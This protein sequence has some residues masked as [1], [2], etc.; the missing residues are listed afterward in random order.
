MV[1]RYIPDR[2]D[3]V[4]IKF[5]PQT[6]HEQAG[7]RPALVISP[8]CIGNISVVAFYIFSSY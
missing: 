6:G 3:I 4:W 5:N 7:R 2:G 8:K 1:E